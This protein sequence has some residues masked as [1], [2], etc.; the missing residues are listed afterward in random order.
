MEKKKKEEIHRINQ[1][2]KIPVNP[3]NLI[4]FYAHCLMHESGWWSHV[5]I[6]VP[7]CEYSGLTSVLSSQIISQHLRL[8]QGVLHHVLN[9]LHTQ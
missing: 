8:L 6:N 9:H 5:K 3:L 7:K 1:N 4:C 2:L